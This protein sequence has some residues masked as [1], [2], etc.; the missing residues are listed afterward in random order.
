VF[1][2]LIKHKY[3]KACDKVFRAMYWAVKRLQMGVG[4][5]TM[6]SVMRFHMRDNILLY[7]VRFE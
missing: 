7:L 4:L 2:R 3:C 5:E 1:T 6:R